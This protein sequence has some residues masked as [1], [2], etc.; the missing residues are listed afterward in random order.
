ML[1]P[2]WVAGEV[3]LVWRPDK[4]GEPQFLH[5]LLPSGLPGLLRAGI[6]QLR[7]RGNRSPNPLC[8]RPPK[9]GAFQLTVWCGEEGHPKGCHLGGEGG[10]VGSKGWRGQE[11]GRP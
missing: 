11:V 7:P 1:W 5:L 2:S 4:E 10:D 8:T 9:R 6:R 3:T